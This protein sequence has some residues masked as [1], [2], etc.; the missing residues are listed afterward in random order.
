MIS[1]T[2]KSGDWKGKKHVPVIHVEKAVAGED[3]EVRLVIG[4]GIPHPNTFEHYIGWIKLFF[5]PESFAAP[6]EV[7]NVEFKAQ[8]ESDIFSKFEA[9]VKFSAK[10]SGQL[11]AISYFNIHG[12]W[13]SEAELKF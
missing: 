11:Y 10:E 2:I 13:E 7:A 9:T 6:I 1:N 3:V 5:K 8:G 12:L 4:E